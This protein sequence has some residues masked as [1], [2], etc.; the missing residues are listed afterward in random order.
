MT[1]FSMSNM[2]Y[3]PVKFMIKC[4]EAN[5]P[6]SL[7]AI[8]VH[9]APWIFQGIWTIIK[10]W[11]DPVVAGKVHFTKHLDD[12]EHFIPKSQIIRELGGSEEW[13]YRY[14]EPIPG[15]NDALDDH[16]TRSK[17]IS[18]REQQVS[19]FQQRTFDWVSSSSSATTNPADLRRERDALARRIHE[20]YWALDPYIRSRT[21]YDRTGMI[22]RGGKINFYPPSKDAGADAGA[23]A[24]AGL[25]T[26]AATANGGAPPPSVAASA[27]DVD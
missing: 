2:D 7:G 25:A 5:Y 13:A 15:E 11:L 8:L 10:G 20:N 9:K 27:D 24:G 3:G 22:G 16:A 6:E 23:G 14:V 17:I 19:R 26:A 12:L 4:F 1:H 21:L 18:E